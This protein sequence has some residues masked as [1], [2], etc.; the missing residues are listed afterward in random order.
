MNPQ[1]PKSLAKDWKA[2]QAKFIAGKDC[3]T[4]YG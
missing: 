2:E 3:F 1:Q 4:K